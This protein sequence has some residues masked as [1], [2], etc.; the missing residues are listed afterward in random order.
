MFL[1][2]AGAPG[3]VV[4]WTRNERGACFFIAPCRKLVARRRRGGL[5]LRRGRMVALRLTRFA[6]SLCIF[7]TEHLPHKL[8]Y[9]GYVA[10]S[11]RCL[12]LKIA[13][14]FCSLLHTKAAILETGSVGHCVLIYWT[15]AFSNARSTVHT[16]QN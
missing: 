5:P 10:L 11:K 3:A 7:P 2:R 1:L 6:L 9:G 16:F 15:F 14:A 13:F 8:I 12:P 4:R